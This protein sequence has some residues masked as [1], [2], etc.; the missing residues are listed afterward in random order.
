M[1]LYQWPWELY[2][3]FFLLS[4]ILAVVAALGRPSQTR[5]LRLAALISLG[6]GVVLLVGGLAVGAP[7]DLSGQAVL[8]APNAADPLKSRVYTVAPAND[9]FREAILAAETQQSWF[10]PWR[11]VVQRPTVVSGGTIQVNIP[12][13]LW[14]DVLVA[15]IRP[16]EKGVQVDA[17]ARSP[18]GVFAFGAP[19]RHV[20]QF[21]AALDG[22]IARQ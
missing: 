3:L 4:L 14:N 10:R 18:L 17:Q 15:N 21:L 16:E 22:R 8:S 9:I 20:A 7:L 12:G 5:Q 11:V 13:L 6:L 1:T 2:L 19:R